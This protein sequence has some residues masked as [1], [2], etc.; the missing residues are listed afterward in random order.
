MDET[1]DDSDFMDALD[2]INQVVDDISEDIDEVIQGLSCGF[3]GGSCFANPLNWAPLAPGN[4][5][6]LMGRPMGDGLHVNEG[7]PIF[8]ALTGRQASCGF[9]SCC[10]PSVWPANSA[11]FVP[12]PVCGPSSAGGSRGTWSGTNFVRVF[13][14]PTLTGGAGI[15]V[16]FGGPAITAGNANPMGAHPVVPGGNCIVAAMPLFG[17]EGG[18]GDPG[19]LGYPFPGNGLD[20]IHANCDGDISSPL[21]TPSSFQDAFVQE[22]LRYLRTGVQ[23][24]G[25]YEQYMTELTRMSEQS[26]GNYTLPTQPLINI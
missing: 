11:A 18:E 20:V 25:L 3:G 14:T 8:S 26:G 21:A 7:I 10:L 1:D 22:Y 12:G 2:Q 16:C 4:D 6:T 9:S 5:I 23:P 13:A 19:S 15:A 17:C 24:E